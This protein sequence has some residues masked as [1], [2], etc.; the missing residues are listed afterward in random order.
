ML[1]DLKGRRTVCCRRS[2]AVWSQPSRTLAAISG[3]KSATGGVRSSVL[4]WRRE[5]D[6]NPRYGFPYTRFPSE[7]HQPLGH[8][9]ATLRDAAWSA[10]SCGGRTIV[11]G[12][13]LARHCRAIGIVAPSRAA[14]FRSGRP[15]IG[16]GGDGRHPGAR[17]RPRPCKAAAQSTLSA[18]W[19]TIPTIS[20]VPIRTIRA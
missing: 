2:V 17:R 11:T 18:P 6:S 3:I 13:G 9:S 14:R 7:R 20:C 15:G 5:W 8:P 19:P 10:Q 4:N 12:S 16:P 1:L